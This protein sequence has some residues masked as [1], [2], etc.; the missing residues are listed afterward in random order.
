MPSITRR[1]ALSGAAA[2]LTGFAGCSGESS[3]SSSYPPEDVD[4]VAVDPESYSLRTRGDDPLMWTGERPTPR[5]DEE[6]SH[7]RHHTFV[8][9]AGAAADVSF[10]AVPGADEARAFL[11]DTDYD[12]ATVYVEQWRVRECFAPKLCHVRW[13]ETDIDTSYSRRYRD[14][15]VACETEAEDTIATLIRIPAAFDPSEVNSYGSSYGSGT[16]EER[17]ERIRRRR[18]ESGRAE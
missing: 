14:A 5:D 16:C 4:N 12:A 11:D 9:S 3:S 6:R 7:Y 1:R 2:L 17:N 18:N 8:T 10:A 13:S 15:D